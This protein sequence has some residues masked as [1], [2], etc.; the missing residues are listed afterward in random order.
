MLN[1]AVLFGDPFGFLAAPST[2]MGVAV[3]RPLRMNNLDKHLFLAHNNVQKYSADD[4][5]SRHLA[6]HHCT[7]YAPG[8]DSLNN[9][10][11]IIR[12]IGLH[13]P[14]LTDICLDIVYKTART[15]RFGMCGPTSTRIL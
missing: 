15:S 10:R 1:L 11:M 12:L 14:K 3:A 8:L 2:G 13:H 7:S 4:G 9:T 5:T 6:L